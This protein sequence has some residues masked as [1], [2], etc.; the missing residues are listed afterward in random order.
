M[1][2]ASLMEEPCQ[3]ATPNIKKN[4]VLGMMA[5]ENMEV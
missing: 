4:A 3:M 1:A 2:M 5:G